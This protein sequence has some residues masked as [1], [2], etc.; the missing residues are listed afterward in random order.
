MPRDLRHAMSKARLV[1]PP[2]RGPGDMASA[3][4]TPQTPARMSWH[5]GCALPSRGLRRVAGVA[6]ADVVVVAGV[7][8]ALYCV[9][10]V[11]LLLA[12]VQ[13]PSRCSAARVLT[14]CTAPP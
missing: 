6:R 12:V 5:C 3:G 1:V 7:A 4:T 2:L 10:T 13:F 8:R 9:P 11:L 14:S